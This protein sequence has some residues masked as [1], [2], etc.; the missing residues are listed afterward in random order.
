MERERFLVHATAV[1]I[2][3]AAVLL[4]GP[5][6]SGKSDLALRLIHEGA[7]TGGSGRGG[8]LLIADDQVQLEVTDGRLMAFAPSQIAGLME[9]R[10]IGIVRLETAGPMPVRLIVDLKPAAEIERL[11]PEGQSETILGVAV[12]RVEI[13]AR[14]ASAPLKVR[15]ALGIAQD[16]RD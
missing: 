10:G 7:T 2:G 14:A 1:A 6:G 16:A 5:S 4:R 8:T 13:D 3:G 11:P 9:V 15:L 12:A